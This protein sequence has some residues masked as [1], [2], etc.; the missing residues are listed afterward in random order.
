MSSKTLNRIRQKFTKSIFF[1]MVNTQAHHV[2]L[3]QKLYTR[4]GFKLQLSCVAC[5]EQYDVYKDGK[6]IAY[7][8][9]RHGVFTVHI[10]QGNQVI[11]LYKVYP[12][13]DGIFTDD[14]RLNYLATALR[15]VIKNYQTT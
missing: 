4:N 14:E 1:N 5:S 6:Q 9:L 10:T 8:R 12:N 3:A 7:Y 13:G 2:P 15:I 11:E